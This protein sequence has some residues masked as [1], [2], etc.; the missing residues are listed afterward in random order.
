VT[1]KPSD[2]AE[3]MVL[4]TAQFGM[5]YGIANVSGKPSKQEVFN[6]LELA[7]ERGVRRFDTAPGYGSEDLLGEFIANNGME[8]EAIVLT[9]LSG[10]K[11]GDD[12]KSVIKS[13]LESS[14][15]KL[16]C[17]IEVLFFHDPKD[18]E[19]LMNNPSFFKS[20]LDEYPVSTLGVSVYEQREVEMLK[21]CELDL[22]FQF[23]FNVLDR[24]FERVDMF[25]GKRY[26]RSVFL[27]GI[28][29]S[30][31]GL[32]SNAP[33]GLLNLQEEYHKHLNDKNLD[34]VIF[35]VSFVMH[36]DCADYFL[37]GVETKKQLN[38]ILR[39]EPYINLNTAIMDMSLSK[40]AEKWINPKTWS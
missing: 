33:E 6:I 15:K 22:A 5:D 29:A 21:D 14:L 8:N 27:Q 25:A 17:K 2:I 12:Y 19:L 30:D 16:G 3:K 28:L 4:G 31:N 20:L 34:P 36:S 10:L 40:M 23:P 11:E 39:Q 35:A 13:S 38:D 37:L 1:E 9:K 18:S 26:A 7:W 32:R 24:R